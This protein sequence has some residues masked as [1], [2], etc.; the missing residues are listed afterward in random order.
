MEVGNWKIAQN[1]KG[2]LG[3]QY[4]KG[5]EELVAGWYF[6]HLKSQRII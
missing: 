4:Y 1:W 6:F 2:F 3:K 5:E